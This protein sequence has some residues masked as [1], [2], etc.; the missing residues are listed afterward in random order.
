[1][2]RRPPRSTLFPYTT[3]FRSGNGTTANPSTG[4]P[5]SSVPVAVSGIAGAASITTGAYHTC[6]LL[7]DGTVRCWGRNGDGQLGD[8]TPTNS[9]TPVPVA[10]VTGAVA[11]TGGGGR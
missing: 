8:G 6:V 11:V 5:G 7:G 4:P 9:A 1:M 2:I 10:G 3:L